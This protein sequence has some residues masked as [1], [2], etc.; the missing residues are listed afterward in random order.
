MWLGISFAQLSL[1]RYDSIPVIEAADT[2]KNAWTGGLNSTLFS[3][4]DLDQDGIKDIFIFEKD[5]FIIRTFINDDAEYHYAP[6]YRQ[7]FPKMTVFA[8]LADYNCDGKEDIFSFAPGLGGMAVYKNISTQLGGLEFSLVTN[9]LKADYNP[10]YFNLYVAATDVPALTDMDGDGDMD[11]LAWSNSGVTVNYFKNLSM[12]THGNCDSLM[13][14]LT[15]ACWGKFL[16]TAGNPVS[17]PYNCKGPLTNPEEERQCACP[18]NLLAI[19]MDGDSDKDLVLGR[20]SFKNMV[21]LTNGG[22]A[23]SAAI[24]AQDLSFP[25]NTTPVNIL[26]PVGFYFDAN[27]DSLKDLIVSSNT[28]SGTENFT[29]VWLYSNTGTNDFPVFNFQKKKFLQETMIDLGSGCNP[30]FFD[31]NSDGLM[32]IV[33]GNYG[34]FNTVTGRYEGKLALFENGGT[35]TAP[36]YKLADRNY[37]NISADTLNALYPA[38]GDIDGDGDK[39]MLIGEYDGELFL[40]EN[41]AGAGNPAN[42]SFVAAKYKNIDVGHFAAPQIIDLNRDGLPDL[43]VGE[44]DGTLNYFQNKGTLTVPDFNSAPTIDTLGGIDVEIPCCT[45]YNAPFLFEDAQG[46]FSLLVGSQKGTIYYYTNIDGNLN[47]NFTLTD[48]ILTGEYRVS[49]S[50]ADI[51]NDGKNEIAVGS[52]PGGMHLLKSDFVVKELEAGSWKPGVQVYPNPTHGKIEVRGERSEMEN[53]EIYNVFGEVIYRIP[54]AGIRVTN[55][56]DLS[57]Q[58]QGIYF[59]R[60]SSG[61]KIR[62]KKIVKI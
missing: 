48:S 15:D 49:I 36:L 55:T 42:F 57:N 20:L 40:Y 24:T 28:Q 19:N 35:A 44:Q 27:N 31:Y 12:E 33:V 38:F 7:P 34:Y 43:L 45:G 59:L 46:V 60:V 51:N 61:E 23:N 14:K 25:S 26:Y 11:I 39:D 32:D 16:E 9:I 37:E 13:F 10:G 4:I 2:F 50:M 41:T 8:F 22:D 6:E 30:A 29:S 53:I 3:E 17:F 5:G 54:H 58:L 18:A 62:V 52:Y 1:S 56:I 47:G 21:L